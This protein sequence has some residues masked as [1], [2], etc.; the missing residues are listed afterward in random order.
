MYYVWLARGVR[1]ARAAGWGRPLTAAGGKLFSANLAPSPVFSRMG[2]QCLHF[3][4]QDRHQR[5][6]NGG[7]SLS[8]FRILSLPTRNRSVKWLCWCEHLPSSDAN[9]CRSTV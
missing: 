2:V 5:I 4:F 1:D 8:S 6:Y 9:S 7:R 3:V